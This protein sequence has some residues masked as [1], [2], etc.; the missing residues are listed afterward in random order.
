MS[1]R[2]MVTSLGGL[3]QKRQLV[4]LGATDWMLTR[5][6]RGGEVHRARQGWYSTFPESEPVLRAAR[7][8][9][10]LTGI[11]ALVELG[12]WTWQEHPLHVSVPHRAARLRKQWDRFSRLDPALSTDVVLHWDDDGVVAR[13]GSQLVSLTDAFVRVVLDE[14]FELAV[15]AFDWGLRTG[16]LNRRGLE[17]ILLAL[18]DDARMIA[19]WIDVRCDSILESIARTG[20]QLHGFLVTSQVPVGRLER[21]DLVIEDIVA[22]ETDGDLHLGRS[23]KDRRKDISITIEG[24]HALRAT[25]TMV[26]Y[27]FDRLVEAIESAIVARH[28]GWS[29]EKSGCSVRPAHRGRRRWRMLDGSSTRL[30][31][32]PRGGGRMRTGMISRIAQLAPV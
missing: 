19:N 10:R 16:C 29:L 5:A 3:A 9:G 13:G 25:Y 18:P 24:R 28:P 30:P 4:A 12:C 20:L 22:L 6:V 1:I 27:E 23:E 17:R 32:F 2:E 31:E 14:P 11:S 7:V 8:G 15:A 21:I 26:R